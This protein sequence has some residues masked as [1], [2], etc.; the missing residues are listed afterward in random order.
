MAGRGSKKIT[1][2]ELLSFDYL[3]KYKTYDVLEDILKILAENDIKLD[4]DKSYNKN[5]F[6]YSSLEIINN[7]KETFLK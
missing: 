5:I 4:F 1:D 6:L 7:L 3:I 2:P